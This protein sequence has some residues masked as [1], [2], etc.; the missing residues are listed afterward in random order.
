MWCVNRVNLWKSRGVLPMALVLS[1]CQI[2]P[3]SQMTFYMVYLMADEYE[4]RPGCWSSNS[5]AVADGVS[6][7]QWICCYEILVVLRLE[8]Q[9]TQT[10]CI[11]TDRTNFVYYGYTE[12]QRLSLSAIAGRLNHSSYS[13]WATVLTSSG[14]SARRMQRTWYRLI[15]YLTV[16]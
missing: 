2:S 9:R 15:V 12:R 6:R 16:C 13:V 5:D 4:N 14:L 7:I 10:V 3:R 11:V 8:G 1:L